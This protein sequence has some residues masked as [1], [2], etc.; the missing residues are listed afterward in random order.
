[1]NAP[2][3][4]PV[5]PAAIEQE[6]VPQAAPAPRSVAIPVTFNIDDMDSWAAARQQPLPSS[7]KAWGR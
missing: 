5:I 3:Q 7:F 1:M 4:H 2:L 6:T